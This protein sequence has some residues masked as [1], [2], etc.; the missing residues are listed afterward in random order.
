[1]RAPAGIGEAH[2]A[3]GMCRTCYI[4][5]L[6]VGGGLELERGWKARGRFEGSMVK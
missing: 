4:D 2:F 5:F 1:M 3:H 6:K